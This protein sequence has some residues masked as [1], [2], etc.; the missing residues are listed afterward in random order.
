MCEPARACVCVC[1][2][3]RIHNP[4]IFEQERREAASVRMERKEVVPLRTERKE[5]D[6]RH[7]LSTGFLLPILHNMAMA[8]DSYPCAGQKQASY[9]YTAC[10]DT[11]TSLPGSN[12]GTVHSRAVKSDVTSL[13]M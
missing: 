1:V 3:G 8:R 4:A 7:E 5:A 10:G 12:T 9:L 6:L 2:L 11:D 13:S